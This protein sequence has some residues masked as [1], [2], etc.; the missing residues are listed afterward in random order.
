[1]ELRQY[2]QDALAAILQEWD[3]GRKSTLLVLP[4]GTGKTIVFAGL[5]E[6]L[7]RERQARVL[8]L[9][10]RAELLQQAA[11]KIY[12]VCGLR[13]AVEKAE[14]TALG[15]WE[16]VT[17]GSVQTLMREKRLEQHPPNYYTHIVVDE[18]HHA[19]ADSYQ[20]ILQYF[21]GAQVLGVTATP[22]RGDQRDLGGYFE[23]LAYQYSL[24]EAIRDG[25]L[26]RIT[27]QTIPLQ[28]D[29]TKVRQSAGDYSAADTGHALEPYLA[30]IAHE[31]ATV[32][33][34]RKTVIFLPLIQTS[35]RMRDLLEAEGMRAAEV[36]GESRDRA[37]VLAAFDSGEYHVLCN[38]MLLTEG[39]DCPSVDSIVCLRP[40]RIRSLYAQIVGRGTRIHPGKRD[41]LLLDFLWLTSRHDLARPAHLVAGSDEVAQAMTRV[42]EES[43]RAVDLQQLEI[44]AEEVVIHEREEALAKE[45][46]KMRRRKRSLV[47]PLQFAMSSLD[48]SLASYVPV[49]PWEQEAPTSETLERLEAAGIYAGDITTAG[50]AKALLDTLEQRTIQGLATPKQV[51]LLEQRGFQ[52]VGN[53]SFSAA[54]NMIGRIA[55]NGWRTPNVDVRTYTPPADEPEM[56]L[57]FNG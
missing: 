25:F 37:E 19:L 39:W 5:I 7:V 17:V 1:M 40:T 46:A 53:W 51:R 50:H 23:S 18:A 36:N 54:Q 10:H 8:V 13:C 49:F 6:Q 27:A 16:R 34:D 15:A 56:V 20:R 4:T 22:D 21:S 2:Q 12:A 30:E 52:H 11:D 35:Q 45:L 38:S 28:L 32:C 44:D 48:S 42:S 14:E 55:A 29:L 31:I 3:S 24:P 43:G 9:A 26:C 57:N 47:D 41:L 33:A